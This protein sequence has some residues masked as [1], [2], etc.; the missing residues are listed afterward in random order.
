MRFP[1]TALVL[2]L[3]ATLSPL[4]AA[5]EPNHKVLIELFTSQG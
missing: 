2:L 4:A 1:R 5:E 3:L